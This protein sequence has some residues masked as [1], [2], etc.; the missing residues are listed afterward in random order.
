M[1]EDTTP[2]DPHL[3]Q[4]RDRRAAKQDASSLPPSQIGSPRRRSGFCRKF[5]DK[6]INQCRCSQNNGPSLNPSPVDAIPSGQD[7][8]PVRW[9]QPEP[10]NPEVV[11]ERIRDATGAITGI[12]P[13]SGIAKNVVSEIGNVQTVLDEF[14]MWTGILGPL[15]VFNTV[16]RRIGEIHPYL[17]AAV[18]I[19]VGASQIIIDQV[20]RDDAVYRL[21]EKI[22]EV[23]ALLTEEEELKNISS[24]L[25]IYLKIAQQT[26]E[27]ADFIVHY[28]ETKSFW[29]RLRK[30]VINETNASIQSY[31][32]VFDDLMQQFRD[33]VARDT[34]I[35]LHRAAEDLDLSSLEYATGAGLNTSKLCLE[36]TREGILTEIKSWINNTGENVP[37]VFWLSGTAGK[38]KSAI[39]HTIANWFH[40]SGRLG[41]C[42]CFT[43]TENRHHEKIVTTIAR[44]LADGNLILRREIAHVVRNDNELRHTQDITRQWQKLIIEPIGNASL[45]ITR[46]ILIVIDALDESGAAKSR[47]QILRLLAGTSD[48]SSS[49]PTKFPSHFRVLVT[50]RLLPDIH[51]TLHDLSHVLHVSMDDISSASAEHDIQLYLS[52]KLASVS[53]DLKDTDFNLLAQKSD[54][55]F[56]WARLASAHI[57]N[58]N[59]VGDPIRRL[60]SVV[61][62]TFG[63]GVHLLDDMYQR[64]LGEIISEDEEEVVPMFRSVMGQIIASSEPLPMVA[65]NAMRLHFPNE[66]D[67]YKVEAVMGPL[68]SLVI[69]TA[70]PDIP[71]RPLHSSF[72]EF[73]TEKRRSGKFSIDVSSVQ[74]DLAFASL[75]VMARGLRFNICSL[76]SSYF[77]NYAVPDLEKRV[78][79]FIPVELSYSCRFWGTHLKATSFEPSLAKEVE[80]FFDG[81]RFLFWLETL[82]LVKALNSTARSLSSVADWFTHNVEYMHTSDDARDTQHF[83]QTF[84]TTILHSTPHLYLSALPFAPTQSTIFRKFAARFPRTPRVVAGHVAL[85]SLN[86]NRHYG[87]AGVMSVAISPDRKHIV[88]G[89]YDGTI[90][91]WDMETGEALGAPLRGH[92]EAVRCIAISSN[93]KRIVSGSNDHTIRLWDLETGKALGPPLRG[94]TTYVLSIAISPDGQRIVSSGEKTIL[95]WDAQTGELL[96]APLE[97]HTDVVRSVA[98]SPNGRHIVSGS[99]DA[100]IR[101]WDLETGEALGPPLREHTDAIL[102]LTISPDGKRIVFGSS[103][104]TIQVLDAETG[105]ALG[106]PLQGHTHRV[107]SVAISADGKL[108]ASG[109]SDKTVRVWDA[110]TGNALGAPLQGHTQPVYS[111]AFSPEGKRIVSGSYDTTIRVWDLDFANKHQPLI[112]GGPVICFSSNPSHA[113]CSAFSFLHDSPAPASLAPNE[114]GWV[115]GPEGRLLLRIPVDL[116]QSVY[117]PGDTL[118]IPSHTLQ[119]DLSHFAHGILWSKCRAAH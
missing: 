75:R 60:R 6:V 111:V 55:L 92:S 12:R 100:T 95:V 115:E 62:A 80:A 107:W 14:D 47:E 70:D 118:V 48:T 39:A 61:S 97:G 72:Y 50:S 71:I 59:I 29:K 53:A 65:L 84:G 63:K 38:G 119:L 33:K 91:V 34:V 113:L 57:K 82:T 85:W 68:G 20:D 21:L 19:L 49:Q 45:T 15:K 16:A 116:H 3:P 94:H 108:I 27:C 28:S 89:S 36:G 96:V 17:K 67:R 35:F 37:P 8:V 31:N 23:Y 58:T 103:D 43:C 18:T 88:C 112:S 117:I 76:E 93:G 11:S 110:E 44:D 26:Q 13:L 30:H 78:K 86:E 66:D 52:N 5:W 25:P 54:G 83:I 79:D 102:C 81:E 9:P 74:S 41:A 42:F 64:I 90:Q 77:P 56:E 105:K 4:G 69:G 2:S 22:S 73:L 7:L 109:S 101:V 106:A 40:V 51:D 32:Q 24:M 99:D 98:I 114:E 1:N 10:L 104:K 46:P 87:H